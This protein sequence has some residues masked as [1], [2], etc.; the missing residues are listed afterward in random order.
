MCEKIEDDPKL[1]GIQTWKDLY[2]EISKAKE[3]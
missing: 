3:F 2:K 1:N